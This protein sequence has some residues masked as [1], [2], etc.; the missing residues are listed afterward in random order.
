LLLGKFVLHG[1]RVCFM[2]TP[3]LGGACDYHVATNTVYTE[4]YWDGSQ[5]DIEFQAESENCSFYENKTMSDCSTQDG[6]MLISRHS[7]LLLHKVHQISWQFQQDGSFLKRASSCCKCAHHQEQWQCCSCNDT[8]RDQ[9]NLQ[10]NKQHPQIPSS[11]S[12]S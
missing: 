10:H 7:I 3:L 12:N 9:Q 4:I 1:W 2:E 8:Q 6:F 5:R 11:E